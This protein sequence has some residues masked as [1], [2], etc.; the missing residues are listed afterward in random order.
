MGRVGRLTGAALVLLAIS[1]AADD[2]RRERHDDSEHRVHELMERTHEGRRSPYRRLRRAVAGEVTPWPEVERAVQ[3]FEPM[4]RALRE[5]GNADIRDAADGYVDAV[6]ELAAATRKRDAA[7][8]RAG[9]E[10][11]R[12]SC[13]D[14][15]YDGGVGGA[16]ED[17]ALIEVDGAGIEPATH[18]FSVRCSTN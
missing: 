18:G 9:F 1:A 5:S 15:H 11:L 16:L 14:C 17:D 13:G 10:S 2:E 4:V 8:V 7:A 12:Q 3:E 6:R